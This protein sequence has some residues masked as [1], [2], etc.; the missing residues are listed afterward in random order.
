M[1]LGLTE[2]EIDG[3]TVVVVAGEVDLT[4]APRL[5]EALVRHGTAAC[6]SV[7]ADLGAVQFLDSTGLGVLVG[8]LKRCRTFGGGLHLVV[9]RPRVRQV[10]ELTGLT[11]VLPLHADAE[12]AVAAAT[13]RPEA[14]NGVG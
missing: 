5:R 11:T 6:P 14:G 7:V 9:T 1:D 12:A 13:S 2:R 3:V 4:T 10:F 8:V